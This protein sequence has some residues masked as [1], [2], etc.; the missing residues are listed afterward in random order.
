MITD[1]ELERLWINL[2]YSSGVCLERLKNLGI[3]CGAMFEPR[4]FRIQSRSDNQST[5]TYGPS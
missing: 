1:N 5:A 2:N 3:V 4:T